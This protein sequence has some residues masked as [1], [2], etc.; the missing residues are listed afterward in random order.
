MLG[1]ILGLRLLTTLRWWTKELFDAHVRSAEPALV[2][3]HATTEILVMDGARMS[4]RL[5]RAL[6]P[7]IRRFAPKIKVVPKGIIFWE[8]G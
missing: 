7:A 4:S 6:L 5:E 1:D 8:A 2:A 3:G